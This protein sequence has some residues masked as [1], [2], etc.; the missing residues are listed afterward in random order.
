MANPLPSPPKP[1]KG[2]ALKWPEGPTGAA[3]SLAHSPTRSA[4]GRLLDS[5]PPTI[6]SCLAGSQL[7]TARELVRQQR[8]A[9]V[10]PTLP[11]AVPAFDGLL[12]GGLC[13][14]QLVE[15][16]G[17]RSCGR[18]STV[19]AALAAMTQSGEAAALVDLGDGL[20]PA[21][22]ASSGIE[23]ERLL[24]LRPTR[25]KAALQATE[26]VLASGFPLVVLELGAPPLA[27]SRA[28]APFW[29]RLAHTT[30]ERRAALLVSSPYRVSGPAATLVV[31]ASH[32]RPRWRGTGLAPILLDGL[33]SRLVLE[34]SRGR[35]PGAADELRL[36]AAGVLPAQVPAVNQV[37]VNQVA[38]NQ[39][40]VNRPRPAFAVAG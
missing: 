19:L 25:L 9:P 39:V 3:P 10:E 13:R 8:S 24:W 34:K 32:G 11:T 22:A 26:M 1:A 4:L 35:S 12:A 37:A 6:A 14:G 28:A 23:L 27:G 15:F 31:R 21:A 30:R 18:F 33:V 20:D 2:I 38:V 7:K 17:A 16:V 36:M 40:A 5:L 29:L